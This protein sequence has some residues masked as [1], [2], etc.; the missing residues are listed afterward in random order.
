MTN[1]TS[2]ITPQEIHKPSSPKSPP[3]NWDGK[4]ANTEK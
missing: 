3:R 4:T 1:V 2:S